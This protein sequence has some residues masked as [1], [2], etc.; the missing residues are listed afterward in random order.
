[1]SEDNA[2]KIGVFARVQGV[3]RPTIPSRRMDEV[4]AE[5]VPDTQP[6]RVRLT[7]DVAELPR[8]MHSRLVSENHH[9]LAEVM[10]E[11]VDE[12]VS[13]H[14]IESPHPADCSSSD[15]ESRAAYRT[16]RVG[17]DGR[18]VAMRASPSRRTATG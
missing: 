13:P 3:W 12:S 7:D 15:V 8:Q 4:V 14:R 18:E 11:R 6:H 17:P 1:M 16:I 5:T 9:P 10:M 2:R